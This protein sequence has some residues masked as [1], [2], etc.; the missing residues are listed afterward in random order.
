MNQNGILCSK[1]FKASM[2]AKAAHP[3]R[4]YMAAVS[5]LIHTRGLAGCINE[6]DAMDRALRA[7]ARR[8][9]P[10]FVVDD[11]SENLALKTQLGLSTDDEKSLFWDSFA[12]AALNDQ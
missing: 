1:V 7:S 2:G 11:P 6:A 5:A 8:I 9:I 3:R 10:T 12:A 4:A